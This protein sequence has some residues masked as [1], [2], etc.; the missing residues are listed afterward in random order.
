MLQGDGFI[1]A[2]R[3]SAQ[4][5]A[6]TDTSYMH[7]TGMMISDIPTSL[8]KWMIMVIFRLEPPDIAMRGKRGMAELMLEILYKKDHILLANQLKENQ[9]FFFRDTNP[10]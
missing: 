9:V 6:I 1:S 3:Y 4:K 8:C 5:Q 10:L 7:Q 2:Y